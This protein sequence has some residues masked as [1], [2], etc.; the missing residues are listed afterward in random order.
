MAS[1]GA[2]AIP[3]LQAVSSGEKGLPAIS[4]KTSTFKLNLWMVTPI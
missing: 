2:E 1:A 3:N 4:I